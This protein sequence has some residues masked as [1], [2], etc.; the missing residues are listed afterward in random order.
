MINDEFNDFII[1]D[2]YLGQSQTIASKRQAVWSIS[3]N[4]HSGY[5]P[6]SF[7][8]EGTQH[9]CVFPRYILFNESD[10]SIGVGLTNMDTT[11]RSAYPAI[12]VFFIKNLV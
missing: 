1:S 8:C 5:T 10:M 4:N 9:E 11:S 2:R 7:I 12:R 3:V 6:I